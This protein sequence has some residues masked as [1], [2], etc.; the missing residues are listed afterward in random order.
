VH[1]FWSSHKEKRPWLRPSMKGAA[2]IELKLNGRPRELTRRGRG[3]GMG[4]GR[5]A[6][7]GA[8][9]GAPWGEGC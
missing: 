8:R 5:G 6:Q 3:G 1:P 7:Q 2:M 4:R 9:L